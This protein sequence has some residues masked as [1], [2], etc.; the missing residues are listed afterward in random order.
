MEMTMTRS[1]SVLGSMDIVQA[2][3]AAASNVP[4][5]PSE[6]SQSSRMGPLEPKRSSHQLFQRPPEQAIP[7][8]HWNQSPWTVPAAASIMTRIRFASRGPC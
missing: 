8:E 6:W 2:L 4:L 3:S 1:W 5:Y 7:V